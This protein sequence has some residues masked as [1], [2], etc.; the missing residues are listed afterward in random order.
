MSADL[1]DCAAALKQCKTIAV[2]GLSAN[3]NKPSYSVA[4]FMQRVGYVVVP[5]NPAWDQEL[6]GNRCFG[7]LIDIPF[8]IDMV[9]CFRPT[10]QIM[11]FAQQAV[12]IGAK[13]FWQQLG[14]DNQAATELARA[15]GLI[16]IANRCLKIEYLRLDGSHS[17]QGG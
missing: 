12:E 5:V 15:S 13:C 11:P 2:V 17:M 1:N 9:C 7:Q 16:A 10:A 14:I 4:A 6:L 3:V 8:A